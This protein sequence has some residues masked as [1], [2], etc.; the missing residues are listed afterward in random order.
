VGCGVTHGES[1]AATAT[2]EHSVVEDAAP[3]SASAI[4][5]QNKIE[6]EADEKYPPKRHFTYIISEL[7]L[8]TFSGFQ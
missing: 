5:I 3:W 4:S 7:D 2:C 8:G 6:P 1:D